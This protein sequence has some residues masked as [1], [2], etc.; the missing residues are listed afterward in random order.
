MQKAHL[1][2]HFG[3]YFPGFGGLPDL[4][5]FQFALVVVPGEGSHKG[6]VNAG[7]WERPTELVPF[8]L[9]DSWITIVAEV[10]A[11]KKLWWVWFRIENYRTHDMQVGRAN[12]RT[13]LGRQGHSRDSVLDLVRTIF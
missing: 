11:S 2:S 7:L 9:F 12:Q 5:R 8:P 6:K 3:G 10:V 1:G 4:L 13:G